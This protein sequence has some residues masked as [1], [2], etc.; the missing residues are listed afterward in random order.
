MVSEVL[1]PTLFQEAIT[2]AVA[3]HAQSR[4][5]IGIELTLALAL[6]LQQP[7][8]DHKIRLGYRSDP[9]ESHVPDDAI[10]R[11]AAGL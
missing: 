9:E 1:T 6:A 5:S 7:K 2:K 11:R 10:A 4:G 3:V 8:I